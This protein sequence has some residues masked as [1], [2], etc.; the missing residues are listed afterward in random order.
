MP[1]ILGFFIGS[2]LVILLPDYFPKYKIELVQ[3]VK[4]QNREGFYNDFDQD[5]KSEFLFLARSGRYGINQSVCIYPYNK[6]LY[7]QCPFPQINLTRDLVNNIFVQFADYDKNGINE[8][9]FFTRT[10]DSL[11]IETTEFPSPVLR[12]KYIGQICILNGTEDFSI[13]NTEQSDL[14]QDGYNELIFAVS[15]AYCGKHRNL[16][17]FDVYNDSVYRCPEMYA[18]LQGTPII[19]SDSTTGKTYITVSTY[20]SDNYKGEI[21]EEIIDDTSSWLLVFDE[22][23]DFSFKP[24]KCKGYSSQVIAYF[25]SNSNQTF[26]ISMFLEVVNSSKICKIIIYNLEGNE[27]ARKEFPT[28]IF[29][30]RIFISNQDGNDHIYCQINGHNVIEY[31]FGLNPINQLEMPFGANV[32]YQEDFDLDGEKEFMLYNVDE[33]KMYISRADL[34]HPVELSFPFDYRC[35]YSIKRNGKNDPYIAFDTKEYLLIY[36]YYQNKLYLLKYPFFISLFILSYFLFFIL[37]KVRNE[38]VLRREKEMMQLQYRSLKNQ[39]DPHF[40]LNVLNSISGMYGNQ[41]QEEADKY[42][43]RFSKLIQQSLM[44]SDRISV[45]LKEELEFTRNFIDVQRTRFENCFEY[46]IEVDEE[47]KLDIEIPRMLIHTFVENAIKHGLLPKKEGGFLLIRASKNRKVIHISIEDNG[48]GRKQ[49]QTQKT[50]GTGKGLAII[51]NILEL[52]KKLSGKRIKNRVVDLDEIGQ[53][54]TRV[55][56]EVPG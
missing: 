32:E 12:E 39:I 11:F 29:D 31:D 54:G 50:H 36:H 5:G 23:L 17:A 53:T 41:R 46:S 33:N 14:N 20:A 47:V 3:K 44:N 2:L 52:Y 8:M 19:Y 56:I 24:I 10:K 25:A 37:I 4:S 21:N 49:S 27:I 51:D 45:S 6:F 38:T 34:S 30:F 16:Y 9:I 42:M 7:W 15:G 43:V 48:I 55:E 13:T 26:L 35:K 40:T 1:L 28:G 22:K 18:N